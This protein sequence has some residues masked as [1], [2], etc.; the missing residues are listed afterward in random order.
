M[1]PESASLTLI[2]PCAPQQL[3]ALL[4]LFES[5][6]TVWLAALMPP[7]TPLA[8]MEARHGQDD[9][10]SRHRRIERQG[11][12]V[13][14]DD[15]GEHRGDCSPLVVREFCSSTSTRRGTWPKTS[16]SPDPNVTIEVQPSQTRSRPAAGTARLRSERFARTWTSSSAA[17]NSSEL[18]PTSSP[19]GVSPRRRSLLSPASWHRSRLT[20]TSC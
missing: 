7:M 13:E 16:V 20:T 3:S 19:E 11:W 6:A 17:Q 15:H 12:R 4:T 1:I 8:L 18:A 2:V 9:S 10:L 5:L 14:D